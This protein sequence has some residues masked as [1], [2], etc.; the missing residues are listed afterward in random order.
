LEDLLTNNR[1]ESIYLHIPQWIERL[2]FLNNVKFLFLIDDLD[3]CLPENTLKMLESIKL[4]LDVPGCSFVLA[5]DDDVVER[6]VEHHYREYR[7][8]NNQLIYINQQEDKADTRHAEQH[9]AVAPITGSE[10]LEKIVQL[11]FRIPPNDNI[12]VKDFILKRYKNLF[13]I[14]TKK[15]ITKEEKE[16][17]DKKLLELF[18]K[19]IPPYPRKIIRAL[20]L[21][22]TKLKIIQKFDS[23]ADKVLIAKIAM[24]ELFTPKLFRF[25]KNSILE[26]ERLQQWCNDENINSLSETNKISTSIEQNIKNQKE[27]ELTEKI[28]TILREVNSARVAFDL[29]NIFKEPFNR[30]ILQSYIQLKEIKKETTITIKEDNIAKTLPA[31]KEEFES[32]LFSNDPISWEKA[33]SQDANLKENYLDIQNYKDFKEKAKVFITNPDWL[34]IVAKHLSK[35]DLID[36]VKNTNLIEEL[37][38]ESADAKK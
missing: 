23:Q 37:A 17:I 20:S 19:T 32:Y 3:R 26:F 36:L 28:N 30:E 14:D 16:K 38:K 33:F 12:D 24:L 29:D 21:Y 31:N 18:I 22:K 25:L 5:I 13:D 10:Y 27:K 11:P 4:F 6:G 15:D 9:S 34:A 2:S 7:L 35:S 1:L 8:Q